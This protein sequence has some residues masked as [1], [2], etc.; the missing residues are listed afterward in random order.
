LQELDGV[1]PSNPLFVQEGYSAVYCNSLALKAIGLDPA[2]G[3]R[4]S[5]AGLASFQRP[6]ALY[7]AMPPTSPAQREQ[8][9]TDFMH[10]LNSTGLTGVYSLGQS[11]FLKARAAKGPMPLRLWETLPFNAADPAAATNAAALIE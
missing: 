5:A 8:N 11:D 9:L 10:E 7:D 3:A 1:A 2:G 4:R 6:Y